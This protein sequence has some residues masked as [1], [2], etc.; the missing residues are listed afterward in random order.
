LPAENGQ[1]ENI[2]TAVTEVSERMTLLL[3]DEAADLGHEEITLN[4]GDDDDVPAPAP[5]PEPEHKTIP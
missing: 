4:L 5:A 1:P 2:A 3:H